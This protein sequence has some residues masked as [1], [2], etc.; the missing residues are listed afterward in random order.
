MTVQQNND[1]GKITLIP[2]GWLDTASS[3]DLN[4]AVEAISEMTEL[5]LDFSQVEYMAS[6]GLRAVVAASKKAKALEVPFSVI[7]V[8]P[9]VMS[10]FRMTGIDKK[11]TL[12]EKDA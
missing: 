9:G 2:E 1:N 4:D 5:V 10:I 6:A 12:I 7:H 11:L 3:P 8:C